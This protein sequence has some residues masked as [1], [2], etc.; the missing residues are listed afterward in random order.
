M[1]NAIGEN[2]DEREAFE[3]AILDGKQCKLDNFRSGQAAAL[4]DSFR[5][6]NDIAPGSVC[7]EV[8][9]PTGSTWAQCVQSIEQYLDQEDRRSGSA[10]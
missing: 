3:Q 1:T 2:V 7:E 4:L 5:E 6:C 9:V 8:D 10:A